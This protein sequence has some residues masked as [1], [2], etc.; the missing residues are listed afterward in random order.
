MYTKNI[1]MTHISHL[2]VKIEADSTRFRYIENV[3]E[4]DIG[5]KTITG[6]FVINKAACF[7]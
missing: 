2:R 5:L 7:Y 4:R 6:S 3:L 1:I